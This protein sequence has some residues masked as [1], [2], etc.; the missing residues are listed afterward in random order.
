MSNDA[1]SNQACNTKASLWHCS[2]QAC[3]KKASLWHLHLHL[4][5]LRIPSKCNQLV[6]TEL[7]PQMPGQSAANLQPKYL[8]RAK[9][10]PD[11]QKWYQNPPRYPPVT[12][13]PLCVRHRWSLYTAL[14]SCR[15]STA[16]VWEQAYGRLDQ[17]GQA[18]IND[19]PCRLICC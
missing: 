17:Q 1:S 5:L 8:R 12:Q 18:P 7:S 6:T 3:N 13:C 10:A 19:Q 2:N 11:C 15:C 4:H 14:D 9:M 16:D